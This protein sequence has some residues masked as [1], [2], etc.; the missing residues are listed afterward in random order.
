[1]FRELW[2]T[3]RVVASAREMLEAIVEESV[4]A[5]DAVS[6]GGGQ[7]EHVRFLSFLKS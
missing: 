4:I 1:M 6:I 5:G 3:G 2:L 7:I